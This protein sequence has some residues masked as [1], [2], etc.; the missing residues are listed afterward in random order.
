VVHRHRGSERSPSTQGYRLALHQTKVIRKEAKTTS[1]Q[2][3]LIHKEAN[4]VRVQ[5]KVTRGL[6]G[7]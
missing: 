6:A 7:F 3:M 1:N 4:V 2:T 5:G